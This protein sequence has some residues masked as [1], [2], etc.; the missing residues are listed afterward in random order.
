MKALTQRAP[1][2]EDSALFSGFFWLDPFAVPA[3]AQVRQT[4]RELNTI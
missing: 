4:V 1:D 3:P 2:A